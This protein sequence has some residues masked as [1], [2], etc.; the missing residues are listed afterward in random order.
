MVAHIL[1]RIHF[2]TSQS[3]SQLVSTCSQSMTDIMMES[4][5][6]MAVD[7]MRYLSMGSAHILVGS[8]GLLKLKH[9]ECARIVLRTQQRMNFGLVNYLMQLTTT[10][11]RTVQLIPAVKYASSMGI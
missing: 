4:A 10:L 8:L 2:T 7:H 3:A 6:N 9:L 5:V 1:A 11:A